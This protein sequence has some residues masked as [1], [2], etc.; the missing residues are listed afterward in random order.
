MKDGWSG[1]K[2]REY[3]R[4]VDEQKE[5]KRGW[6]APD[7]EGSR[8]GTSMYVRCAHGALLTLHGAHYCVC[9]FDFCAGRVDAG[10]MLVTV[11]AAHA[12]GR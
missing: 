6:N 8:E 7:S 3:E 5:R 12:H 9:V 10:G 4:R 1:V 11:G 2:E